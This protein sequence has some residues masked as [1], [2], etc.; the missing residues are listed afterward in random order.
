MIKYKM[1]I[2]TLLY[3]VVVAGLFGFANHRNAMRKIVKS[4]IIFE[5]QDALFVTKNEVNNLLIQSLG[6]LKNKSKEKVFLKVLEDGVQRNSMIEKAEVYITI[7]GV[8]KTKVLQKKPIARVVANGTSY[9]LD[10][11]GR[12]MGLSKNYSARVPIVRGVFGNDA[13]ENVYQFIKIV[14]KDDFM[15]QQIIGI[16][17]KN[18]QFFDLKTKMG[19]IIVEFGSIENATNKINKLKAFYQKMTKDK[20]LNKYRKVNLE[21]SKQVV[22]TK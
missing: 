13:L 1:Y 4:Q 19:N 12:K 5:N 21:Y 10:R 22:C 16:D 17:I 18:N 20:S 9:Y 7:D 3:L 15:K 2:K 6:N 11:N 14:L 8:L